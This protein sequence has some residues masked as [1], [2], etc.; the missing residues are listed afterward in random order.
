MLCFI[1]MGGVAFL[2]YTASNTCCIYNDDEFISIWIFLLC[3]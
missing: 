1:L 3:F 2:V